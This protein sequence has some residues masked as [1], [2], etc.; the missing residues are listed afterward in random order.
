MKAKKIN[1]KLTLN[2]QTVANLNLSEMRNSKGGATEPGI[3]TTEPVLICTLETC[4]PLQ[5]GPSLECPTDTID[6]DCNSVYGTCA[7][8]TCEWGFTCNC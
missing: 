1:K 5:C 3:C 2:K 7:G 4:K 8:M 6:D